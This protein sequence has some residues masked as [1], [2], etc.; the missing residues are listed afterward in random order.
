MKTAVLVETNHI[1]IKDELRPEPGPGQILIR[2][3]AVGLCGSDIH[4]FKG[5][6]DHEPDTVYPFVLGHEYAGEI[7]AIGPGV[8]G[9]AEGNRVLCSPDL[10]CGECEWCESGNENVCPNVRFS[11]SAGVPG[12]LREYYVVHHSQLHAVPDSVS[13]AEATL[14]EPLAIGLHIID[15]LV[16]PAGG[17]SYAVIG[18]GPIGL[19]SAFCARLRGADN[20]YVSDKIAARAEESR[21]YGA[22]DICVAEND[23][24]FVDFIDSK[25]GNQGVDVVIEAAGEIDSIAQAAL[26]ARIHGQVIIEGIP[27]GGK[28]ALEADSAR[29]KELTVVFGRRSLRKTDEAMELIASEKFNAKGMITHEFPLSEAQKAFDLTRD[30]RDGV[31]KTIIYP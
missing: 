22:D 11:A 30:Y 18:A 25:T 4:Y 26:L 16:R 28:A 21:R 19:V 15:N 1:E 5:C 29:R 7:A 8:D 12:C 2:V 10:P 14:C 23:D 17:E 31:I 24:D 20:I 9:F 6:R 13:L 3:R 27:P